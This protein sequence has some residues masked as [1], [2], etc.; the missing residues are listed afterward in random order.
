MHVLLLRDFE[1]A[2]IFSGEILR[3]IECEGSFGYKGGFVY[4]IL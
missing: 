2:F 4:W 3:A 1:I